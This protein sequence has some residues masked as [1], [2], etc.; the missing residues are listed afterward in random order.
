MPESEG[1]SVN[2][3]TG[4]SPLEEYSLHLF[5]EL[6]EASAL[7]INPS[8][9]RKLLCREKGYQLPMATP[10]YTTLYVVGGR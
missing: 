8:K 2:R 9:K 7:G 4:L 5:C 6:R 10:L 1:S 3:E